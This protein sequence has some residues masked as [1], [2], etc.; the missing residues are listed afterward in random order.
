MARLAIKLP[1]FSPF[2]AGIN[3]LS[4]C[5][6]VLV[7]AGHVHCDAHFIDGAS[8]SLEMTSSRFGP[9]DA[10]KRLID[11]AH[12]LGLYVLLDVVRWDWLA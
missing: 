7:V 12:G 3:M 10:L 5:D 9:A 2:L 11:T 1:I 4:A 6:S 8:C